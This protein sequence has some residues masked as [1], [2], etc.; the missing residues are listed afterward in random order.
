[1][2][3]EEFCLF[4]FSH[5][6]QPVLTKKWMLGMRKAHQVETLQLEAVHAASLAAIHVVSQ[7]QDDLQR[8]RGAD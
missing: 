8:S 7:C 5:E 6:A 4:F 2:D 3:V 1:M